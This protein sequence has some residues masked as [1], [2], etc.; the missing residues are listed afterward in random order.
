[1]RF[2]A[3]LMVTAAGFPHFPPVLSQTAQIGKLPRLQSS[4]DGAMMQ[5]RKPAKSPP[6]HTRPSLTP[7]Q[8]SFD[9]S[10]NRRFDSLPNQQPSAATQGTERRG[11]SLASCNLF[12]CIGMPLLLCFFSFRPSARVPHAPKSWTLAARKNVTYGRGK[13]YRTRREK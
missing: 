11:T 4:Y 3:R 8:L 12:F 1:M 2:A 6:V 13:V 7:P 10:T 5:W 9:D